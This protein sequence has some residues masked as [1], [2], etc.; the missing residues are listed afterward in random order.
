MTIGKQVKKALKA[1]KLTNRA[2][3]QEIGLSESMVSKICH[4]KRK[5]S[6]EQL[7][8]IGK[9]LNISLDKLTEDI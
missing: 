8:N 4:N 2:F 7:K 3:A 5:P 9:A 1:K 6:T